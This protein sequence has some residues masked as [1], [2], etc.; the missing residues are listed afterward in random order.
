MQLTCAERLERTLRQKA[1][2]FIAFERACAETQ[3]AEAEW[4]KEAEMMM[5]YITAR[6]EAACI[7]SA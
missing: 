3:E 2:D 7:L 4:C 5:S 6:G 1:L